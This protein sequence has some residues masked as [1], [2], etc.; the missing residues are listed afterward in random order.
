MLNP[1]HFVNNKYLVPQIEENGAQ[2][3]AFFDVLNVLN[4]NFEIKRFVV[5]WFS[6]L[7]TFCVLTF[8]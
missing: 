8:Y 5:N 3:V 7:E 4:V 2:I 6:F 1:L